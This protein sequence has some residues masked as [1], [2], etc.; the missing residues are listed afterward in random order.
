MN[1]ITLGTPN[2]FLKGVAEQIFYD[3]ATGNIVGF[4]NVASES[5]IQTSVNLQEVVGGL[6][7]TLV[8]VFPDT[9]RL[10]GTYTSQAFSLETRRLITGGVLAYNATAPVCKTIT[11]TGETL[12]IDLAGGDPTPV[13]HYGQ[14]ASDETA[15]CFVKPQG[16]ASYAGTNYQINPANGQVVNYTAESGKT[17][18]VYY[19]AENASAQ[20]LAIPDVF[21]PTNVTVSTKYGV[22]AKQNNAVTGGTL[23]GWLYVVVPVAILSGDAG[24]SANQTTNATTDGS[25]MALSP[26]SVGLSCADCAMSGNPLAYYVYVP[27]GNATAEVQALAIPGGGVTVAV[28]STVQIPVKY[29]MPNDTLVQ[30]T[31]TDMN[32]TSAATGTATVTTSG[33]VEGVAAGST[34]IT[35]ALKDNSDITAVCNVTVTSA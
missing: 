20:S 6:G 2:L 1:A 16:A 23:Q 34:T 29:V 19:F 25:W 30:P 22:Y 18:E 10:T 21:N 13:K 3:P 4:D 17:Y 7:N 28:G 11:A 8:G 9:V 12:S 35:V 31:Y 27:C 24:I 14:P 26:D 32:Y 15:W 33:V 5:A